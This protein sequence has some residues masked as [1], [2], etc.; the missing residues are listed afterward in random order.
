VYAQNGQETHDSRATDAPRRRESLSNSGR[1]VREGNASQ[2]DGQRAK[3]HQL[4]RM[5]SSGVIGIALFAEL[6]ER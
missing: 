1:R 6:G 2:R 5:S 4:R 3:S